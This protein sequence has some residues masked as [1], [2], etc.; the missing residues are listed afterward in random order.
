[1]E[2]LIDENK[3]ALD[4]YTLEDAPITIGAT[5][6]PNEAASGIT[7]HSLNEE[8]ATVD[9]YGTVTPKGWGTTY[10]YITAPAIRDYAASTRIVTV[11]VL[12]YASIDVQ[13]EPP[14]RVELGAGQGTKD[15]YHL[16]VEQ[17]DG[18]DAPLTFSIEDTSIATIDQHGNITGLALGQTKIKITAA[19]VKDV[20]REASVEVDLEVIPVN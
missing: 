12:P 5:T 19:A 11:T 15:P 7:Y 9:E 2:I 20:C 4:F 8:I 16:N 14:I 1:M 10:I 18:Q 3:L 6:F 13:G 17:P